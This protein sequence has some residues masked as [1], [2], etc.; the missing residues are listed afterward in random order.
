MSLDAHDYY[1]ITLSLFDNS[2]NMLKPC[3][4]IIVPKGGLLTPTQ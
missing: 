1:T 4:F 2:V 3:N